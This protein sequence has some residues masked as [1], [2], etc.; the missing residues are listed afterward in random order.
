M[1]IKDEGKVIEASEEQLENE[2]ASMYSRPF[3]I[4]TSL[5]EEQHA[6]AYEEIVRT[7]LG[8]LTLFKPLQRKK[9]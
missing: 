8:M 4:D 9:A 2:F 7:V 3:A 1:E 6:N 5:N